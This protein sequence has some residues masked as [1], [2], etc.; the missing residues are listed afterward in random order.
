M[1][2]KQ[3][4]LDFFAKVCSQAI[5]FG[6]KRSLR[7]SSKTRRGQAYYDVE[8]AVRPDGSTTELKLGTL[9]LART[10]LAG[11]MRWGGGTLN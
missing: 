10:T 2:F 1:V 5:Q 3:Y 9:V 6:P 7:P 11:S 8:F 4:C